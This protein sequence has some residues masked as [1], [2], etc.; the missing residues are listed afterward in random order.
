MIFGIDVSTCE[1]MGLPH[2]CNPRY[3]QSGKSQDI[4]SPAKT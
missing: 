2:Q 1:E 4:N 3:A